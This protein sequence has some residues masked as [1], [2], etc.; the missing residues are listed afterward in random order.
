MKFKGKEFLEDIRKLKK[1]KNTDKVKYKMFMKTLCGVYNT[2]EKTIYREMAKPTPGVRKTRKDAGK[3]KTTITP[4]EKA[5]VRELL[6]SGE[7]KTKVKKVLEKITGKKTSTR[8][9]YKIDKKVKNMK[10]DKETTFGKNIQSFLER[11]FELI[12]WNESK[13]KT[14]KLGSYVFPVNKDDI[15]D[16]VL[17]LTNAYNRYAEMNGKKLLKIDRLDLMRSKLY[18]LL[19]YRLKI[20]ESETDLKTMESLTDIYNKLRVKQTNLPLDYKV[21]ENILKS[22]KPDITIDEIISLLKEHG[23]K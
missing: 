18:N 16:V 3:S 9:L 23:E 17:V 11:Y 2:S 1:Y 15:N 22:F 21:L 12:Y 19:A 13:E 7:K 10:P 4:K 5:I 14:I 6:D 20:A 8:K